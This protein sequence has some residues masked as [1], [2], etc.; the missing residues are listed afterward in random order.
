MEL[1]EFKIPDNKG[2]HLLVALN[3]YDSDQKN[4]IF[5]IP[6][7]WSSVE[8]IEINITKEH[9]NKPIDVHVFFKL[10]RELLCIFNQH[11][12][13]IMFYEVSFDE[14]LLNQRHSYLTPSDYRKKFF[15]TLKL[16]V[17]KQG[18]GNNVLIIDTE[19]GPDGFVNHVRIFFRKKHLELVEQVTPYISGKYN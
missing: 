8:I 6:R 16:W 3:F 11:E 4:N 5:K 14:L 12:N 13:A 15:D 2:N 18:C 10:C 1:L 17:E 7:K 19:V 9:V